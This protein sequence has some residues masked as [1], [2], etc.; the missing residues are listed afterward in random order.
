MTFEVA[1]R[2]KKIKPSATLAIDAKAKILIAEG[3]P[4]INLGVGEPD[5]DTPSFI[6]DAA[7][8]AINKGYTKYTAVP[9]LLHLREAIA[10]RY[11]ADKQ[12]H[13]APNEI[14]VSNGAKQA[15][16]NAMQVLLNPGDEVII[17]APYWVS[18]PEM[19]SLTGAE[20][21]IVKSNFEQKFKITAADLRAAISPRSRLFILN[22]PNNPSG[23]YYTKAELEA[24]AEVLLAYP[25]LFILSDDIYEKIVWEKNDLLHLLE[26]CPDLK[27][28]TILINGVSKAY[29]MTG[30]RIGYAAGP[31]EIIKAMGTLQSQCTSN[32]NTIAQYASIAALTSS[33]NEVQNMVEIFKKRHALLVNGLSQIPGLRVQGS[34]GTFYLLLDCS[35][36][37]AKHPHIKNDFM[38]AEALLHEANLAVV[39]GSAFGIENCLRL[40]Y[41]THETHLEKAILRL[42]N[43][44]TQAL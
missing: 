38:L 24:L 14:I 37:I 6:K 22:S 34:Q 9:G 7:I 1:Q 17:P 31:Q 25:Q 2:L 43:F 26:I 39:P 8:A 13:F 28:R 21:I 42:Q 19:V 16:Y 33:D 41:A 27:N 30:W 5:F 23:M 10:A 36:W 11:A 35:N 20:S 18:Y 15:L 40:S 32:A 3:K 29:A 44:L 12:L 4:V